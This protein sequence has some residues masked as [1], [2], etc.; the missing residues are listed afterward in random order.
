MT[1]SQRIRLTTL[2][3]II[4][5]SMCT[6]NHAGSAQITY[7]SSAAPSV[8]TNFTQQTRLTSGKTADN[9]AN[10]GVDISGNTAVV[11]SD[12]GVYVFVRSERPGHNKPY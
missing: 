11:A 3:A 4:A 12:D 2:F 7:Q 1:P 6:L 8:P 5:L 9:Y 10:I